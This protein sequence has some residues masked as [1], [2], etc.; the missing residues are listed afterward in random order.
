MTLSNETKRALSR[1]I[2]IPYDV[3]IKMDDEEIDQHIKEKV[4]TKI[5]WPKG[6]T[7]DG[8]PIR[9]IEDVDRWIENLVKKRNVGDFER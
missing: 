3:L 4:G 5:K 8:Y 9:P 1:I 7:V 6:A 2:G